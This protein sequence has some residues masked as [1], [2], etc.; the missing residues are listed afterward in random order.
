MEFVD[1]AVF[2]ESVGDTESGDPA[3]V[4]AAVDVFDDGRTES[5]F[6]GSVFESH[7]M[8][9]LIAYQVKNVCIDR[10]SETHVVVC[11]RNSLFVKLADSLLCS[12][13]EWSE[14]EYGGICAVGYQ[15]CGSDGYFV[16]W[17]LPVDDR[18]AAAR[19]SDY[20]RSFVR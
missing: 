15:S 19:V 13:A 16:H 2:D 7:N 1:R 20:D 18:A 17:L 9:E 12:D 3:V 8:F 4:V 6:Y 14:S 11:D 10:L 5:A